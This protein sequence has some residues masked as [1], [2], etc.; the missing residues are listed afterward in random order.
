MKVKNISPI[1]QTVI[2][3]DDLGNRV[4]KTVKPGDILDMSDEEGGNL[5]KNAG[6]EFVPGDDESKDMVQSSY[7]KVKDG[8]DVR[9]ETGTADQAAKEIARGKKMEKVE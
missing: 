3:T 5:V 1:S 6:R 2:V 9:K 8:E 7:E 4:V